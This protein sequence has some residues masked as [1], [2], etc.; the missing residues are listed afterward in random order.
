M[1]RW[2]QQITFIYV[3]NLANSHRFYVENLGFELLVDQGDCRIYQTS[4]H[5]YLG[6]CERPELVDAPGSFLLTLVTP[7]V[8]EELERFAHAGVRIDTP[9]QVNERYAITQGF[10]R[11][12]DGYRIEIQR[13]H[14]ANWHTRPH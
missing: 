6:L 11:D 5:G 4:S 1:G 12:P 2:Q 3:S 7:K 13:F 9:A 10:V 8:E 14:D